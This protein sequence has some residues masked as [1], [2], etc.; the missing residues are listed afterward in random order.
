M[1]EC[2]GC[3][4]CCYIG[5]VPQID[6]PPHSPCPKLCNGCYLY[7]SPERPK[8]CTDFAC[9]WLRELVPEECRPDKVGVMLS[10]NQT[11]R[12]IIGFAIELEQGALTGKAKEAVSVLARDT[13]LPVVGVKHG[14]LPPDDTGDWIIVRDDVLPKCGT[15]GDEVARLAD[16]VAMHEL[17]EVG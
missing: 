15:A 10:V 9:A 13:F 6:K 3:T 12:G 2:G 7:G 4:V 5:A 17:V 8:V 16:D 14:R 1:R 11:E